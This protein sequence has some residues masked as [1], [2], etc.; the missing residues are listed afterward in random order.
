MDFLFIDETGDPG[1]NGSKYFGYGLIHVNSKCYSSIRRLLFNYRLFSGMFPEVHNLPQKPITH[2]NL[3]R[4]ISA[5]AETGLIAITGLYIEKETYGGRYL[6]W[7]EKELNIPQSEWPYYL[8][9]YLLRHLL[10][11]HFEGKTAVEDTDLVLDRVT[12]TEDQRKNTIE[13]LNSKTLALKKPFSLPAIKYLT[14]AD[15]EYVGG[16]QLAHIIAELINSHANGKISAE[17][18]ELSQKFRIVKFEGHDE[19]E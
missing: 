15:S 19:H 12:L 4:G 18:K 6:N 14:V 7:L 16:L 3:L 9:N 13:Y 11:A 5:L 10:E 17:Q 1:K 2:L 8:R